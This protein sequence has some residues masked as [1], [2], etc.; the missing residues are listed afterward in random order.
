MQSVHRY[1]CLL[2]WIHLEGNFTFY[3]FY[4]FNYYIFTSAKLLITY[5]FNLLRCNSTTRNLLNG[6]ISVCFCIC[7]GNFHWKKWITLTDTKRKSEQGEKKYKYFR[8]CISLQFISLQFISNK[9]Q[10]ARIVHS[11]A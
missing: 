6:F 10:C 1:S 4:S 11:V 2:K 3:L 7:L 5:K 8:L 9:A